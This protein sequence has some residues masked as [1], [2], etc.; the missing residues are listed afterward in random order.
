M[1][2]SFSDKWGGVFLVSAIILFMGC[3]KGRHIMIQI[4]NPLNQIRS[5]EMVTISWMEIEKHISESVD[6]VVVR[7]SDGE[8]IISQ[9][10]DLDQDG[11]PEELIF[12]ADFN[13]KEMKE[14]S[15]TS[16]GER[17]NVYESKVHAAFVPDGLEDFNW[18]NDLIGY[19]FYGTARKVE[20]ISSGI[21]VW[22]KRVPYRMIEKWYDPDINYHQD[23]GEGADNYSVKATRG[24]G[25]TALWIN[26]KMVPSEP[27][28]KF[29][30]IAE[31]PLRTVFKL[32]F[33]ALRNEGN[34]IEE[35][36][37]VT[38]DAGA[39]LSQIDVTFE[40]KWNDE[41]PVVIGISDHKNSIHRHHPDGWLRTWEPLGK[42]E[43][44]ELG[45]V[46]I[47]DSPTEKSKFAEKEGHYLLFSEA[48]IGGK[49][50]YYSGACWSEYGDVKTVE[51]W[52]VYIESWIARKRNPLM[53]TFI[54]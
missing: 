27:F 11:K 53:I 38:L 17:K 18:E 28:S 1:N 8:E 50:S 21:D 7:N 42:K 22:C 10:I 33:P 14:F 2:K 48:Q 34:S 19:R 41:I 40:G 9:H 36:K 3:Q 31:G 44:G 15:I 4:E 43:K 13:P 51:D 47:L 23:K 5:N 49:L 25:G 20:G 37:R 16:T 29:K 35:V 45:C 46:V 39:Y 12:H 32:T 6:Q 52:D 54:K 26:G 30:V 24:C